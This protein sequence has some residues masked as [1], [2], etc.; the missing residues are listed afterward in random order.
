MSD[1]NFDQILQDHNSI[2]RYIDPSNLPSNPGQVEITNLKLISPLNF[3]INIDLQ[4]IFTSMEI[5]ENIF[6][7][8]VMNFCM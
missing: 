8:Y 5:S 2:R 7:P 3:N 1:P 4:F 6:S